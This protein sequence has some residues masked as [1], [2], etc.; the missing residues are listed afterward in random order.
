MAEEDIMEKTVFHKDYNLDRKDNIKL[1]PT[2]PAV[3][4]ICAIIHE[5]PVHCR[6]VGEAENLQQAIRNLFEKAGEVSEGFA[7]F[8]HGPWIQRIVFELMPD[9]SPEDRQKAVEEWITKYNPRCD[10]KGEYH[11]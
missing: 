6:Y 7:Q 8:M 5:K 10:E 11:K 9:S 2:D 3:F 4:A 1:I